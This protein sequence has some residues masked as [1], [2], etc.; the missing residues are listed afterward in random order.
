MVGFVK[1]TIGGKLT[2]LKGEELAAYR[3]KIEDVALALTA[4]ANQPVGKMADLEKRVTAGRDAIVNE[5]ACIDCHKFREGGALGSAPDLT[6]YASREWLTAF[7]A[8][9]ADERFYRDTNDRMPAF[10]PHPG[11][12]TNRLRPEELALLV[13]WLRG[14]WYEPGAENPASAV[15][16][17]AKVVA[18]TIEPRRLGH[19]AQ[20]SWL[21]IDAVNVCR[22]VIVS[23]ACAPMSALRLRTAGHSAVASLAERGKN[24]RGKTIHVV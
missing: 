12:L 3:Q 19:I 23:R 5:F 18:P 9:P 10:A 15:N 20:P 13:S 24:C 14:E 22:I 2:E 8:N 16:A 4:E 17:N 1:E 11:D 21:G 6:G 7:I